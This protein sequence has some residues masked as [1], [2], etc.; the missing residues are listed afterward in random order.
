MKDTRSIPLQS[1]TSP[2]ISTLPLTQRS[3]E[4]AAFGYGHRRSSMHFTKVSS[5][6]LCIAM[7][8]GLCRGASRFVQLRFG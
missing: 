3:V 4:W 1:C 8:T 5:I 7:R 2:F 6:A